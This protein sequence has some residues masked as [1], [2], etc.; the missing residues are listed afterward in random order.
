MKNL[1]NILGRDGE[2]LAAQ[3]LKKK[4]YRIIERNWKLGDLET[5]IIAQ[6][7]DIIAF[8]EVKTRSEGTITP[9]E[10][11]VDKL[12]KQRLI[13]G[14]QAYLRKNQLDNPWR[15]DIISI[16]MNDEPEVV[17]FEDAFLPSVRTVGKNTFGTER[18]WKQSERSSRRRGMNK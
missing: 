5:D 17:H 12:R 2:E 4:G 1:H 8:V 18:N 16:I 9:P 15:M 10:K 3:L 13:A 11:A 6:K 7:G 14:A